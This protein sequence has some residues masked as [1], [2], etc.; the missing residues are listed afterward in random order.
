[1]KKIIIT[2]NIGEDPKVSQDR[3]G[4]NYVSFAV[5]IKAPKYQKPEWIYTNCYGDAADFALN[6]LHQGDKVLVEGRPSISTHVNKRGEVIANQ[7]IYVH[8]LELL[9]A[10]PDKSIIV[11]NDTDSDYE[12]DDDFEPRD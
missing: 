12:F 7:R 11:A 4:R 1:M 6:Y 5:A 10:K 8:F 2:G 9:S 3:H